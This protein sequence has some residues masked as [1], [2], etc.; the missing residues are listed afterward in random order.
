[1]AGTKKDSIGHTPGSTPSLLLGR[2]SAGLF[3]TL[4]D[5]EKNINKNLP[6]YKTRKFF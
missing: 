2:D 5:Q 6:S 4:F 1:L 3:R